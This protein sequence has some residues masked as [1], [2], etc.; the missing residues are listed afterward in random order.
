MTAEEILAMSKEGQLNYWIGCLLISI[1]KGQF[2]N[3]VYMM[4]DFY[5]R[6]AF[7][8]GVNSTKESK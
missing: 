4:I 2:R 6:D 1:G 3:E 8:R 5:Q 7:Q